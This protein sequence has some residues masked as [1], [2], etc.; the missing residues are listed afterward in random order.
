MLINCDIGER[1][2]GHEVD[3]ALM[4]HIDIANIACGGHAGDSDSVAYYCELAH[5]LHVRVS[6]HLSY[7]DTVNFGRQ[8]MAIENAALLRTLDTQ[9]ALLPEV[10]TIKLHGALYNEANVNAPLAQLLAAWFQENGIREV[11]TP[12]RSQLDLA[13]EEQGITCIHE[14][15]LDRRYIYGEPTPTIAPRSHSDALITT[16]EQALQQY[17]DLQNGY[18]RIKGKRVA[19]RAQTLCIHSDSDAALAIARAL[20]C[21][22]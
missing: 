18:V 12:H 1:G 3:D 20:S 13:C 9:R 19:L 5:T 14:A 6:V 11:L 22:R 8:V 21:S 4:K 16:A 2:A 10:T 7:P 15:F 17:H